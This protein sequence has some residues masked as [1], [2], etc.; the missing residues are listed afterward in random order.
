MPGRRRIGTALRFGALIGLLL[1][2][3]SLVG[4]GD[5]AADP[6][7]RLTILAVNTSVGRAAFHLECAPEA[8]DLAIPHERAPQLLPNPSW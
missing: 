1:V 5:R 8:G 4:C 7:A 2:V 6:S 3:A